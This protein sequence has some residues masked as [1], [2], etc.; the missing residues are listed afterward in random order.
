[1]EEAGLN[2]MNDKDKTVDR[3]SNDNIKRETVK[4]EVMNKDGGTKRDLS[5]V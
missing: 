4:I 1:M 5:K 2:N 3:V